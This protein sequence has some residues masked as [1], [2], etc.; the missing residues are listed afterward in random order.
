MARARN[1]DGS[2]RN[3]DAAIIEKVWQK[4]QIVR[5]KD[6][7]SYRKDDC[8]NLLYRSSYG[9]ESEMGWEIDHINPVKNGG[10]DNIRNL[11]PL[12]SSENAAKGDT[13]PPKC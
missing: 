1:T 13:Y 10:S 12:K 9:I 5:G 2:G 6:P 8:G 4:G 11:R 7:N 3:F